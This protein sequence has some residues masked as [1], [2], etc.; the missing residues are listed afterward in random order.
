MTSNDFSITKHNLVSDILSR[1]GDIA[2]LMEA[3]GV[4]RL[5]GRGVRKLVGRW[6]TLEDAARLHRVPPDEFVQMVKR[7]VRQTVHRR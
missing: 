7:A 2:E 3:F 4:K 5:A 6:L 1:Y